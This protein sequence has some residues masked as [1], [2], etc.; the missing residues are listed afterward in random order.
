[1]KV[2]VNFLI[3]GILSIIS[4]FTHAW[5]GHATLLPLIDA[6]DFGIMAKTTVFYIWHI[7][8]V[9]NVIFGIAFILMAFNKY[10]SKANFAAWMIVVILAARWAVIFGTTFLKDIQNIQNTLMDSV[11][12]ML[13]IGLI[14]SGISKNKILSR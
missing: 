12:I 3:V 4:G 9:E 7:I 10:Q 1:M 13:L 11:A 2:N 6:A 5:N 8:T 14:L